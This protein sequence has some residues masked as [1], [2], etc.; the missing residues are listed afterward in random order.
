MSPADTL[1]RALDGA[2]LQLADERGRKRPDYYRRRTLRN[3][4]VH[5]LL[6]EATGVPATH[7]APVVIIPDRRRRFDRLQGFPDDYSLVP[8]RRGK[9][10]ADGPRYKAIGNSM[11]VPC[12]AWIGQRIQMVTDLLKTME[13]A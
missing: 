3:Q 11:A 13:A 7:G 9:P 1:N 10:D 6:R 8:Y 5:Q 12:M 4:A 2:G